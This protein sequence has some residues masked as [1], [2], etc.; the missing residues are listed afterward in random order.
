MSDALLRDS[1]G[2]EVR[3][4]L[5]TLRVGPTYQP[6]PRGYPRTGAVEKVTRSEPRRHDHRRPLPRGA[7][8]NYGQTSN[9]QTPQRTDMFK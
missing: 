5:S 7:P 4:P 9:I 1:C 8:T 2:P 3:F 6:G